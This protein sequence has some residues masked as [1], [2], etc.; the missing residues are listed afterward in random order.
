M[1][2]NHFRLVLVAGQDDL[3]SDFGEKPVA[4]ALGSLSQQA[5]SAAHIGERTRCFSVLDEIHVFREA[6]DEAGEFFLEFE[7]VL[8]GGIER[9]DLLGRHPVAIGRPA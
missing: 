5:G 2:L 4:K 8:K 7:V 6:D 3:G 1:R 9:L